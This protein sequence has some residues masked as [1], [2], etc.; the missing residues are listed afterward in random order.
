MKEFSPEIVIHL[1]AER[2]PDVV[3][4]KTQE[5]QVLN[6]DAT[7]SIAKAC[8]QFGAWMIYVS[9]DYVFDGTSPPYFPHDDPNPLSEYGKQKLEGERVT[10]QESPTAAV[11]RVPLLYGQME[12]LKESGVTALYKDLSSGCMKK[13][14]HTQKRYPTY[15]PDV[16]MIIEKMME[17]HCEGKQ[18]QGIFH[19]QAAECLTKFDMVRLIAEIL[20][21]DASAVLADTSEPKFP[22]PEDSCLDCSKLIETLDIDP[23]LFRTPIR[24]ALRQSFHRYAQ[25]ASRSTTLNQ[26]PGKL[27]NACKL[28]VW[29]TVYK[30]SKLTLPESLQDRTIQDPSS[31]SLFNQCVPV[32]VAP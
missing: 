30:E 31:C 10:L 12:F 24:Y 4:K 32:P 3:G 16:A 27:Q 1:A 6:V 19:W 14:D 18:L 11:L 2:R 21:A 17:V 20:H 9:T 22:R 23:T 13:A 28:P 25:E 8:H 15:T 5:S 7:L 26:T 29:S